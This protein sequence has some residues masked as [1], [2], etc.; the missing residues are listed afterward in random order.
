M[1]GHEYKSK[2]KIVQKMTRDGLTEVN[3]HDGKSENI[4]QNKK[5]RMTW[6]TQTGGSFS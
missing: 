4:S 5:E 3:L 1:A 6:A 2:D